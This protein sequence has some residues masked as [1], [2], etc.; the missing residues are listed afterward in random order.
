M[1]PA[2]PGAKSQAKSSISHRNQPG[3]A[4]R[5]GHRSPVGFWQKQ[6]GVAFPSKP[7]SMPWQAGACRH[8]SCQQAQELPA[9]SRKQRHRNKSGFPQLLCL[10]SA[11]MA[12]KNPLLPDACLHRLRKKL[13]STALLHPPAR[14]RLG[15]APERGKSPG[16][17]RFIASGGQGPAFLRADFWLVGPSC[18]QA[19]STPK[20]IPTGC[21]LSWQGQTPQPISLHMSSPMAVASAHTWVSPPKPDPTVAGTH[22]SVSCLQGE[23]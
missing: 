11:G 8:R 1:V 15:D 23:I 20:S 19:T 4:R 16:G 5:E 22:F 6:G 10:T 3:A 2:G 9:G 18:F 21:C 12:D 7:L 14:S 17:C 13:S